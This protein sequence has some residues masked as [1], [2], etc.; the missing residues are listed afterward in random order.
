MKAN[1]LFNA[2]VLCSLV[3]F[4]IVACTA[5][6]PPVQDT[7]TPVADQPPAATP[8]IT[9]KPAAGGEGTQVTVIGTGFL[10]NA[11]VSV[12]LGVPGSDVGQQAYIEGTTDA[13]SNFGVAFAMPG[14]WPDGRR[15][16]ENKLAIVAIANDRQAT[17]EFDYTASAP[18]DPIPTEPTI[19]I[20]PT[21]GSAGTQV[22][23][24]CSGFP[25]NARLKVYVGLPD[26]A[27]G[28]QSY[29]GGMTDA[30]G[31]AAMAFVMPGQWLDGRFI[32]E[33]KLAITVATEDSATSATAEFAYTPPPSADYPTTPEDVVKAFLNSIASDYS[34]S[35]SARYLS[36]NLQ[37]EV[38]NGRS[39]LQILGI[40]NAFKS[41]SVGTA[42]SGAADSASVR[43]ALDLDEGQQTRFFILKKEEDA[44][45]ITAVAAGE[46]ANLGDRGQVVNDFLLSLIK[47]PSGNS[48][49]QYLSQSL[50]AEVQGGR[51]LLSILGIQSVYES[52]AY[53]IL[54]ENSGGVSKIRATLNYAAGSQ[55]R[56][57]TLIQEGAGWHINAITQ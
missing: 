52:F 43:A 4:S 44:W 11:Q 47:D 37:A 57:L 32:T 36:E 3:I 18:P 42:E 48:S 53:E 6:A 34:A 19:S 26:A 49:L 2:F 15:I 35:I 30:N 9:I 21:A 8:S 38:R 13:S 41:F 51:S 22:T 16:T 28:T 27:T 14:Q 46:S 10:P 33:D 25:A 5:S 45:R 1:Q 31:S 50:V 7:P 29:V 20:N 56:T 12:H 40:Q 23:L 55:V 54:I 24:V 39:L 17:A